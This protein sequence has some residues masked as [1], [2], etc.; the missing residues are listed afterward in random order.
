MLEQEK[1]IKYIESL[2][3]EFTGNWFVYEKYRI[4]IV[5]NLGYHLHYNSKY[6]NLDVIKFDNLELLKKL[7][8]S[9]KLKRILE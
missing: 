2:G 1:F 7:E 8:R 9:I 3:F 5:S 4:I 6:L